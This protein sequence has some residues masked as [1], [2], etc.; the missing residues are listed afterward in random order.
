MLN[1]YYFDFFFISYLSLTGARW[2]I[3]LNIQQL[4][5][6]FHRC[7]LSKWP[8][9]LHQLFHFFF[10]IA[11]TSP[12]K[13]YILQLSRW[14]REIS[15]IQQWWHFVIAGIALIKGWLMRLS[16]VL[17]FACDSSFEEEE[18]PLVGGVGFVVLDKTEGTHTQEHECQL[19]GD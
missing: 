12:F 19:E 8:C 5:I 14:L 4:L 2:R 11:K 15:L 1:V 18:A 13:I 6:D 16:T 7:K 10:R 3:Q 17:K 9:P